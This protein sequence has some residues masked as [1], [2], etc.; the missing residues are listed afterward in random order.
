MLRNLWTVQ[1]ATPIEIRMLLAKSYLV[2]TLLYGSEVFYSCDYADQRKLNVA[3]NNIA[4]YIFNKKRNDRISDLAYKIFNMT[5][6]NYLKYRSLLLL[7]KVI[8]N[9]EPSY[10]IKRIKFAQSSRGRR[11]IQLKFKSS[12]SEKQY[13]IPTIRLWNCLPSNIQ[14]ISNH[15]HFKNDLKMF[16]TSND[17]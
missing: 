11:I 1:S 9:N 14:T 8:T 6:E 13:L 3:F 7:H 15:L 12:K 17:L 16:L 4:R 5:F 2:P 10:L